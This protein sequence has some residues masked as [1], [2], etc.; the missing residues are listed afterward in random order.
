MMRKQTLAPSDLSASAPC[1]KYM[2]QRRTLMPPDLSACA[3][4]EN[5]WCGSGHIHRCFCPLVHHPQIHG[6]EADITTSQNVRPCTTRKIHGVEADTYVTEFVCLCTTHK[7]YGAEAD[8]D[9]TGFVCLCT[10]REFVVR[11]RTFPPLLLSASAP[12]A[13]SWCRTRHIHQ[14]KRPPRHHVGAHSCQR[15]TF[16]TDSV[17]IKRSYLFGCIILCVS[18]SQNP[19]PEEAPWSKNARSNESF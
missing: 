8:T 17:G 6:A 14:P 10:M 11:R 15:G 1:A 18:L 2:V 13:D 12:P 4:C 7:T 3:P 9:A 16:R 19:M 5:S